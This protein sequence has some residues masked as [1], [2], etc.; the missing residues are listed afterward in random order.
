MKDKKERTE[1]DEILDSLERLNSIGEFKVFRDNY[2]KPILTQLENDL[3]NADKFS[4]PILRAKLKHYFSMKAQYYE[5]FENIK[6]NRKLN[7]N[8]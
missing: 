4:E 3:K 7:E 1:E 6:L 2:A 8:K 5:V